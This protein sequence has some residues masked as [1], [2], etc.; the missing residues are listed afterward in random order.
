MRKKVFL[1]SCF[2]FF[3]PTFSM[4]RKFK[5]E[6]ERK[7]K[8][9]LL[10]PEKAEKKIN[11]AIGFDSAYKAKLLLDLF[12][13]QLSQEKKNNFLLSCYARPQ[14]AP[15]LLA[16]CANSNVHMKCACLHARWSGLPNSCKQESILHCAASSGNYGV[17]EALLKYNTI[18]DALDIDGETSLM[19]ACRIN[20]TYCNRGDY[21]S[22]YQYI[23]II[24]ILV[25]HGADGTLKNSAGKTALEI[26]QE[27]SDVAVRILI[28]QELKPNKIK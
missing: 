3:Y 23:G 27:I 1:V 25:K 13:S 18:V 20:A 26:A 19:K 8:Y 11:S 4:V 5:T 21:R 12:G 17:V 24:R 15:M 28:T 7:Q 22:I 10:T 2:L 9:S 14:I 6:E 16:L